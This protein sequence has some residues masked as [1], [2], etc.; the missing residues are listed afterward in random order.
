MALQKMAEYSNARLAPTRAISMKIR[1]VCIPGVANQMA[2]MHGAPRI[3]VPRIQG[4]RRPPASA[5]APRTGAPMATR[6]A[7]VEVV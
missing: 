6:K 7:A 4:L 5:I 1:P 3:R 2:A